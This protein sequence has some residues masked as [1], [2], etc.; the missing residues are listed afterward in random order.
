MKR[1]STFFLAFSLS[2][3]AFAQPATPAQLGLQLPPQRHCTPVKDQA[4][5]GTC[6]SFASLSFLESEA[7]RMGAGDFDLSEMFVARHSYLRKIATHL[8][9]KGRN[10]FTP[11]GQFHDVMWVL[12]NHGIVPGYAYSGLKNGAAYHNHALLDTAVAHYVAGLLANGVTELQKSHYR[13]LDS[14][15]DRHLGIVPDNFTYKNRNFT[16]KSFAKSI[17]ALNP[18][19]YLEITSYTHHPFYTRYVVEDK[20]NWTGDLYYNVPVA[21][22]VAIANNAL[23]KGHTVCWDGD[24]TETGFAFENGLAQLEYRG[25]DWQA[26]R[27]RTLNDSTSTI[28][29]LMHITGTAK[30]KR[31]RTWYCVKNSWGESNAAGGYLFMNEAYF[32][33][34]T[35]AIIVHKDAIPKDIARKMG[36]R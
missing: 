26:E 18:D 23:Q 10:Y 6:W 2:I 4:L 3:A 8:R 29:H 32:T 14:L 7:K 12:K 22:F 36:V 21:D 11:G 35:T 24:V 13:Y 16:P 28:D 33:I 30:D 9:L 25:R 5:S 1:S 19:D 34:K 31:G 20:Y 27:Q 15:F 17:L